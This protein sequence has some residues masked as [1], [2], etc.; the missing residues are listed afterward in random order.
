MLLGPLAQNFVGA[1]PS[2][3]SPVLENA[4]ATMATALLSNTALTAPPLT[5]DPN[6]EVQGSFAN[7]G[8]QLTVSG[9]ELVLQLN[10]FSFSPAGR[11]RL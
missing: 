5:L 1:S 8:V 10:D 11:P 2:D 6:V 3:F 9:N 4:Q 7:G